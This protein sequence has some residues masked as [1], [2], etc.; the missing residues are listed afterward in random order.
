MFNPWYVRS[1]SSGTTDLLIEPLV[2][3]PGGP[4]E[5]I[6]VVASNQTSALKVS[7]TL[8]G[9]AVS[10]QVCLISTSPSAIPLL[11]APTTPDGTLNL[12]Y[13]PPGSYLVVGFESGS[14][15]DLLD[16]EVQATFSSHTKSITVTPGEALNLDLDAVPES[17]LQP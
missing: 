15:V 3:S 8:N 11:Q 7:L 12:P 5:P 13:L 17:E 6:Q 9:K 1:I 4:T 16:P 2:L 10:G 14:N